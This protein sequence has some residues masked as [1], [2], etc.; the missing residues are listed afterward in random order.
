MTARKCLFCGGKAD[1]LCD[2]WLGWERMRGDIA[3]EKPSLLDAHSRLIPIKYRHIHTCDAPLCRACAA[4]H[5]NMHVRMQGGSFFETIDYCPGHDRGSLFREL[6][7][8]QAEAIRS[9]WRATV[10][11]SR[12][13]KQAGVQSDMFEVRPFLSMVR[14]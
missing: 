10:R 5:G 9:Q 4:N 13:V 14:P 11:R 1:L 2:S 7:G 12:E 8:L 3:K 6:T